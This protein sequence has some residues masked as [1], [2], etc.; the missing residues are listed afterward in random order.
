[1]IQSITQK[2]RKATGVDDRQFPSN[3]KFG[4]ATASYQVEGAWDEDGKGEN[5]WDHLTHTT[6]DLIYDGSNGDIAC[7]SYHKL[8]EDLALIKD[9]GVDFYR[10]SL[11]WSRILPTGHIDGQINEAGVAYYED[12]LTKLQE[13]DI[14]AMVTLYHWDLP[15]PLQE[16]MGG[17]LN[18]TIVDVYGNYARLAFDLFGDK[19]QYWAT[20]NEPHVVCQQG[21]ESGRKAPAITKAPGIDLYTCAHM[22]LKS[23]AK[24]Y[25]IYDSEYRAT[26]KGKLSGKHSSR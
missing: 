6:P 3:F 7:D 1:M 4:V 9:L 19:V 26:Q 2:I 18:D 17:W 22:V 25:H 13:N 16:H 21:Y 24:A 14:Q 20:F 11:S 23:H 5:I 10:L 8:E 15:Q 12:I